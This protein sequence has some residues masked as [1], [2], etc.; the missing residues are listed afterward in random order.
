M[1][2]NNSL[3]VLERV[4][5]NASS[6]S[7]AQEKFGLIL[8]KS[9]GLDIQPQNIIE[10]YGLL[11][12]ARD[13]AAS[14]KKENIERYVQV[15]DELYVFFVSNDLW[16]GQSNTFAANIQQKNILN[17]L[18]SL[19]DF[20]GSQNPRIILEDD[21]LN[22]LKADFESI[23]NDVSSSELSK[24]LKKFLTKE[25]EQILRGIS[26]YKIDGGEGLEKSIK[27]L[28][29]NLVIG[30]HSIKDKDK[31]NHIYI[32]FISLSLSYL[33]HCTPT[34]W[35]IIGAVPD[36]HDFWIPQYNQ[37]VSGKESI[38]KVVGSCPSIKD[39]IEQL[40]SHIDE[41]P[42]KLIEG[43]GERKSLPPVG[44]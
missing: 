7:K 16:N 13:E 25:I 18:D 1:G 26:R 38:A 35:D 9:M 15:L 10:F 43:K 31:K 33:I 42:Q 2:Q 17:T 30:D 14:I 23:L 28:I 34:P 22:L 3:R 37:I 21:F 11:S 27:Q 24:G 5:T 36:L 29:S 32:G 6:A 40:S 8:L 19:A 39:S 20:F 41:K 44:N 12:R 4:L